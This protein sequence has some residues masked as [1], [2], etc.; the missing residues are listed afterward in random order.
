[1]RGTGKTAPYDQSRGRPVGLYKENIFEGN[2]CLPVFPKPELTPA[3]PTPLPIPV[4]LA[5][6]EI[7][8]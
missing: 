4:D 3:F 8:V 6:V 5:S 1:M 7:Q 2:A